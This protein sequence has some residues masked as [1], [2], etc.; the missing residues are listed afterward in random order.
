MSPIYL[1]LYIQH[2]KD[3][4][5]LYSNYLLF[6]PRIQAF[7]SIASAHHISLQFLLCNLPE[8]EYWETAAEM[9]A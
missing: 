2:H 3:I 5:V 7:T 4:A 9:P 6:Q 1:S 8:Y